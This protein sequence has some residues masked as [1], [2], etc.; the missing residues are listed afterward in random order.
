MLG[1]NS[2]TRCYYAYRQAKIKFKEPFY[3]SFYY[4]GMIDQEETNC[5]IL[6]HGIIIWITEHF[7][8][9]ISIKK[10]SLHRTCF[11]FWNPC[12]IFPCQT[13]FSTYTHTCT[14]IIHLL[15]MVN[16]FSYLGSSFKSSSSKGEKTLEFVPI[17]LHLQ[18]MHVHSPHLKGTIIFF[19]KWANCVS[20][21]F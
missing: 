13:Y 16:F 3:F 1:K 2:N 18:R 21:S 14:I 19:F 10:S 12:N 11:S 6:P 17:N 7:L 4:L 8:N 20:V 5:T 9:W 15:I